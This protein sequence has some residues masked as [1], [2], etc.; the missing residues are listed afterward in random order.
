MPIRV[1]IVENDRQFRET[2]EVVINAS[3]DVRCVSVHPNGEHALR[4]LREATPEVLLVD[5]RMPRLSGIDC[6]RALRALEPRL[7]PLMLTAYD[8]DELIF[9]ALKAGAIGYLLKRTAPEDIVEAIREAHRGG[10]PMT[11]EIARR[12]TQQFHAQEKQPSAGLGLS[13]REREVLLLL[14][15]GKATKE[16]ASVLQLSPSTI[17]SHLRHIYDKL[18]VNSRAGAVAKL[19]PR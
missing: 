8:D 5:I 16:I 14:G 10:S 3:P 2:L 7:L 11:P 19:L 17:N 9:E 13:A 15:D 1:S 18:H 6:V 4:T 12:V